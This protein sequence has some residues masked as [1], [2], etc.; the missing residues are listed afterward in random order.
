MVIWL[1]GCLLAPFVAA[2]GLFLGVSLAYHALVYGVI[3]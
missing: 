3:R 1:L 2:L